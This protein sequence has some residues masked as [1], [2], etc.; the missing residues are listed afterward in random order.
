MR[1]SLNG[2]QDVLALLVRRKWWVIA[3]FIALTCASALLTYLL[4]KTYVS[5][6]LILVRPRDVPKD[7][8][9]IG[10]AHV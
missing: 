9:K 3:P 7:F 5:E 6:T 8:V 4:P 10:R 1:I 2:S